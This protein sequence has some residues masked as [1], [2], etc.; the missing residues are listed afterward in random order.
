MTSRT[1]SRS[2]ARNVAL[3]ATGLTT[4]REKLNHNA[5]SKAGEPGWREIKRSLLTMRALQLD[6][7][8]TIIRTHYMPHFSRHG[9][10]GREMLDKKLFDPALQTKPK[11]QFFEYWGHECS[12]M[13]LSDYPLL[14][15]RM[16]DARQHLGIYKQLANIARSRPAYVKEIKSAIA[17]NGPLLSRELEK[18]KRGPG[19]WEWS[20][21]K[22]ALEYL[23]WT[24]ELTTRGRRGFQRLYELTENSIPSAVLD[25]CTLSRED[26]QDQLLENSLQALG[27]GTEADIRDYYRVSAKDASASI[28]RLCHAGRME[29]VA[30][31]GWG[32][33]AYWLPATP[34]PRTAGR[35]TFLSPFDPLIWNRDRMQ[36]LFNFTYRIEIY[37]PEKQRKYGYY[38]LPFLYKDQLIARA[39][40][41]SD[42]ENGVLRVLGVWW[43]ASWE[44]SV[45]KKSGQPAKAKSAMENSLNE[46]AEWLG[47]ERVQY[48]KQGR[49][50]KV[51]G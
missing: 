19:M 16:Q 7:I 29:P 26:A 35:T 28:Q 42:R 17:S 38:V 21:T 5:S 46:L 33:T 14:Y 22:Q 43:E 31:E 3:A 40:L 1:L 23:F 39:D 36:R 34:V 10:Y 11:R 18:S 45:D 8:N 41:K 15:W 9:S 37:V 48:E 44:A 47:L 6:A 51:I 20:E 2:Q 50:Q 49:R 12:V 32:K 24:G 25:Q 4:K 13:P 30:V 27:I